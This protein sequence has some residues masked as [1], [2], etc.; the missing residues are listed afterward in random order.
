ML[1]DTS[2]Q[3]DPWPAHDQLVEAAANLVL[4]SKKVW[5]EF[6]SDWIDWLNQIGGLNFYHLSRIQKNDDEVD[7]EDVWVQV[8]KS[9]NVPKNSK[10]DESLLVTK[11][12]G[13]KTVR[14]FLS[15][16]L[17]DFKNEREILIKEVQFYNARLG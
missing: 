1:R 15:S 11:R 7:V 13:W 6:D 16:T 9:L 17:K 4:E 10:Y 3:T 2:C 12:T 5:I 14:I 8:D